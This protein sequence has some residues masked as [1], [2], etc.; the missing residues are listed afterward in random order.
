MHL[1]WS[2]SKD[3]IKDIT[4]KMGAGMAEYVWSL[5]VCMAPASDGRSSVF[6]EVSANLAQGTVDQAAYDRHAGNLLTA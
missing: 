5:A 2:G 6:T 3:V 4:D 1:V